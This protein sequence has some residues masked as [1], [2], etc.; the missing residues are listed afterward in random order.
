MKKKW[1]NELRGKLENAS[2]K[3]VSHKDLTSISDSF[4]RI[5]GDEGHQERMDVISEEVQ[6]RS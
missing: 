2:T 3:A 5:H 1:V 4:K 6:K